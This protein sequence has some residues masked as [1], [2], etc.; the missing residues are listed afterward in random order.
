MYTGFL[1][2][3][4]TNLTVT[5]SFFQGNQSGEGGVA[6]FGGDQVRIYNSRFIGNLATSTSTTYGGGCF[7]NAAKYLL[8]SGCAFQDNAAAQHGGVLEQYNWGGTFAHTTDVVNCTFYRNRADSDNN[9]TGGGGAIYQRNAGPTIRLRNCI[10]HNNTSPVGPDINGVAQSVTSLG[11]NFI[12]NLTSAN[13]VGDLATNLPTVTNPNYRDVDGVDNVAGNVDDDLRLRANSI[14]INAGDPNTPL[15]QLQTTDLLAQPRVQQG[16]IDIGAYEQFGCA[17]LAG[18]YVVDDGGTGDYLSLSAAVAALQNCGMSAPVT[19]NILP[20]SGPYVEQV[21]IPF[22]EGIDNLDTLLIQ[23]NGAVLTFSPPTG[24]RYILD[25]NGARNVTVRNLTVDGVAATQVHGIQ[26]R[27]QARRIRIDSCRVYVDSTTNNNNHTCIVASA[28]TS[29]NSMN[30]YNAD[31]LQITHNTLVG[32]G[33][34]ILCYNQGANPNRATL[35]KGNIIRKHHQ[36][37]ISITDTRQLAIE[38]NIITGFPAYAT[39]VG[40]QIYNADNNVRILRNQISEVGTTGLFLNNVGLLAVGRVLIANNLIGSVFYGS[41][42]LRGMQ[43]TSSGSVDVYFNNVWVNTGSGA[44]YFQ[45]V[46][47]VDMRI[48]NNTFS[49]TNGSGYALNIANDLSLAALNYNN[50]FAALGSTMAFYDG[51]VQTTLA[52]L[53]A[54]PGPAGH[55]VNSRAFNPKHISA[56][57]LRLLPSSQLLGQGRFIATLTIDID[58]QVRNNPPTIGADEVVC[59]PQRLYVNEAATGAND[60]SSWAN[61]FVELQDALN[62]A[63]GVADTIWVAGGTYWPDWN[64]T[65]HTLDR[66][67]SFVIGDNLV[68]LGSFAGNETTPDNRDYVA[69][70]TRLTGDLQSNDAANFSNMAD[71]SFHVLKASNVVTGS[72]INGFTIRGGNANGGPI[73]DQ[74]GAGLWMNNARLDISDC[75]FANNTASANTINYGGGAVAAYTGSNLTM[76]RVQVNGNRI[77]GSRGGGVSVQSGQATIQDCRFTGN[78]TPGG[79]GRGLRLVFGGPHAVRSCTFL[80]NSTSTATA[81]GLYLE[82]CQAVVDSC[83]FESNSSGSSWGGAIAALNSVTASVKNSTFLTNEGRLGGAINAD[84]NINLNIFNCFFAGNRALTATTGQGGALYVNSTTGNVQI[85]NCVFTGNLANA[86]GGALFVNSGNTFLRNSTLFGNVANQDNFNTETGGGIN[87]VAGSINVYNSIL[88]NNDNQPGNGVLQNSEFTGTVLTQNNLIQNGPLTNGNINFLPVFVQPPGPDNVIGTLDDNL[89]LKPSSPGL[90]YGQLAQQPQDLADLDEDANTGEFVPFDLDGNT[91]LVGPSIDLGPYEFDC[92]PQKF[93][94]DATATGGNDGSSWTNAF[95]ELQDALSLACG[96]GDT[97]WVADGTYTPD[98]DGLVH[99]FDRNR[100]FVLGGNLFLLGGFAGGELSDAARDPL[101][102]QCI[103]SG[104]L[105]GN[106]NATIVHT[107]PTRSDNAHHVVE[108]IN[109]ASSSTVLD[110]FII[111][112]GNANSAVTSRKYGAGLYTVNSSNFDVRRCVFYRNTAER[113]GGALDVNGNPGFTASDTRFIANHAGQSG[114]GAYVEAGANATFNNC[115]FAHNQANDNGGGISGFNAATMVNTSNC[116][117]WANRADAESNFTG[118]GGGL[119][120][121]GAGSMLNSQN[122]IYWGN[123]R[124]NAVTF[125]D[126]VVVSAA[127]HT[128]DLFGTPCTGTCTGIVSG[129]PLFVNPNGP[130][131]IPGTLDDDLS[132]PF[133]SPAV[134]AGVQGGAPLDDIEGM[135]RGTCAWDIG[136]YEA[137]LAEAFPTFEQVWSGCSGS[138][139]FNP[140]N[141]ASQT[142][143]NATQR[144]MVPAGRPSYP[145]VVG[146]TAD[147]LSIEIATDAGAYLDVNVDMGGV[148]QVHQP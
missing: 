101:L 42:A 92:A 15:T 28:S 99:L 88:W 77:T 94:V 124:T 130:D 66:N 59:G 3:P 14:L 11:Y 7:D 147:C 109:L 103:L 83:H 81:G 26:F 123:T 98:W 89:R 121:F 93:F 4:N 75:I 21:S 79:H 122:T 39:S 133:T 62:M 127:S 6:T 140:S 17:P 137:S 120:L 84:N 50:Y 65:S 90:N 86:G 40:I 12:G 68:L 64:G 34:A 104:D 107:E 30:G 44:A 49:H 96:V 139:W 18:T 24:T 22:I 113:S 10:V 54:Q 132:I 111:T 141:W 110:G 38:D 33:N 31:S 114:G 118:E 37:G 5:N 29:S 23:G 105:N 138:D 48:E 36:G 60:G 135:P 106:D 100:S 73:D 32:G 115:V 117:F 129:D 63:C 70:Q 1:D 72:F 52:N 76:T 78:T 91:R 58:G 13:L 148:L 16:L 61:A 45:D 25:F 80:S 20:G 53:Q 145:Q 125:D 9:G 55:D 51:T 102:N 134:D 67:L 82:S 46:S 144:V 85:G 97:I 112:G 136:A 87:R 35:V 142:I 143:P 2:P 128:S 43:I 146:A 119:Y 95:R 27:N 69:N 56:T 19:F 57:N 71:N 126:V 108:A 74:T 41:G 8:L 116:T 47:C 131:A